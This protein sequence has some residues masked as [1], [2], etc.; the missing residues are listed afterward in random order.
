MYEIYYILKR[1]CITTQK[2]EKSLSNLQL[3]FESKCF[4]SIKKLK[5]DFFDNREKNRIPEFSFDDKAYHM[6][7]PRSS[8]GSKTTI[9]QYAQKIVASDE[10]PNKQLAKMRLFTDG[11]LYTKAFEVFNLTN[12][13]DLTTKKDKIEYYYRAARLYQKTGRQLESM[14]YYVKVISLSNIEKNNYYFAPN[15]ALQLGYIYAQGKNYTQARYYFNLAIAY[16]HHEYENSIEQKAKLAL[17]EI[18]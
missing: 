5:T 17:N 13:S 10:R 6:L 15:S 3:N 9:R 4:L 12:L 2:I 8:D 1:S 7:M 14:E 11:G 16:K 18:K